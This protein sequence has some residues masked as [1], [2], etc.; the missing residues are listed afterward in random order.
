MSLW[1]VLALG[2]AKAPPAPP[3]VV[4]PRP[5]TIAHTNDV[6]GHFE[7]EPADWDPAR[8]PVGGFVRL[9]QEVRA[10]RA[11]RPADSVLVLDG[12][13]Q[14]TGTPLT[15]LEVDGSRGGAMHALF[16][17]VGFDAWAVGNHEFDKG[18]DNLAAYTARHPSLP[19]SANVLAPGGGPLLPKQE[20]SHVFV[21][22][23][24]RV[25]V[26]GLTTQGLATLMGKADF[27]RLQLR[28]E[29]DAAREELARLEPIT[30]LVV[31]LSHIGLENDLALA[32]QVPGIDLI[33]GGHSHTRLPEAKQVGSTWIVQAGSYGRS[34]GVV[35]LTVAADSITSFQYALRDLTPATATVPPDPALSALVDSYRGKIEAEYGEVLAQAPAELGRSYNHESALGRWIADA[36]RDGTGADVAFYNAGGLRADLGPGPVTKGSLFNCFPFG[37]QVMRFQLDGNALMGIVIGN[38][39]A[40]HAEKRGYLSASGLSWT[41]RVR[42]G[43]PEVVDV[44]VGG[45]PLQL[46]RRYTV[47]ASSYVTEQWQKHLGVAPTAPE[48]LGYTDYDAAVAY[49]RK[50]PVVDPPARR[51]TRLAD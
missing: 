38:L 6:H 9:E 35:D 28:S 25:G 3:E 31:V 33:V 26:I 16:G 11:G 8:T 24:L 30:D 42:N 51:G 19:L 12:G 47:V 15:D 48:A 23:G 22:N 4:G 45:Q 49:A 40:E 18:L 34:L 29:V 46:D 41:W 7:P 2:C 32:E 20:L 17:A 1:L 5:L 39:A 50:A 37:N 36:L 14:L 13:D 10:L 27:A 43:A 21:R 44:K